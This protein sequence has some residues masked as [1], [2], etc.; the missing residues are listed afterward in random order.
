MRDWKKFFT[1]ADASI[2]VAGPYDERFISLTIANQLIAQAVEASDKVYSN[3]RGENWDLWEIGYGEG[4][5][6]VAHL[7]NIKPIETT[8]PP[9]PKA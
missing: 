6:H 2:H 8:I 5:T 3:Q 4:D 7:I 9:A 1:K